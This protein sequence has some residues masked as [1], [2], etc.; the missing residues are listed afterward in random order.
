MR[1]HLLWVLPLILVILSGCAGQPSELKV[2]LS[3]KFALAIG[4]SAAI[5]EEGLKIKFIEVIGDSRC[6]Q[7]VQCIWAG[8]ASSLIEITYSGSTYRKVLTQL[9]ASGPALNDFGMYKITFDLQPYPEAGQEIKD[10]DYRLEL[11]FDKTS[12]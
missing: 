11:Q 12:L 10:K 5:T 7:G 1:R 9:G 4:Q 8:E 2:G 6:P 3:Q